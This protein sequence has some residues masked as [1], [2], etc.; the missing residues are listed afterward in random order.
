MKGTVEKHQFIDVNEINCTGVFDRVSVIWL[1]GLRWPGL[2]KVR[3][4]LFRIELI[5]PQY[6]PDFPPRVQELRV[7]WTKVHFGGMRP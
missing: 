7:S 6:R 2:A 1:A 4:D 5:Y 3:I